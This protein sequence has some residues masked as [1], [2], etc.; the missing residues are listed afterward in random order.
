M[1]RYS[2]KLILIGKKGNSLKKLKFSFYKKYR[3][4]SKKKR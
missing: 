1:E 3:I 4:F 2:Q